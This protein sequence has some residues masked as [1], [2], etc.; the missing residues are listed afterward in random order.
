MTWG[1]HFIPLLRDVMIQISDHLP[2]APVL[3]DLAQILE[4]SG[5]WFNK[6][7]CVTA[8]EHG[9]G[10]FATSD[11]PDLRSIMRVPVDLMP[12]LSDFSVST[13]GDRFT[14]PKVI[15][16]PSSEQTDIMAMMID[17]YN[18]SGSLAAWREASPYFSLQEHAQ[19]FDYLVSGMSGSF[20]ETLWEHEGSLGGSFFT[21]RKFALMQDGSSALEHGAVTG[22]TSVLLPMVDLF[23][24][25]MRASGFN[26]SKSSSHENLRVFSRPDPDTRELFVR[27]NLMDAVG[28]YLNYGFVDASAP[29][30]LS[31]RLEMAFRDFKINVARSAAPAVKVPSAF[32]DIPLYMP[33]LAKEDNTVSLSKLVIPGPNAPNA[34]RRVIAL[35]LSGLEVPQAELRA[36]IMT[37]EAQVIEQNFAYWQK[38]LSLIV[39]IPDT[40]A[41]H[42]LTRKALAHLTAYQSTTMT[43]DV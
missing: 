42:H 19:V 21:S 24:H 30:M 31:M 20:P 28:S 9:A 33:M 16:S 36:Q 6:Q 26:F 7:S 12:R 37:F 18:Q 13:E 41:I 39:D 25:D 2:A 10:V 34:L 32:K 27:Y 29:F 43:K 40:H 15:G 1:L 8:T 17:I 23:N 22:K 14:S 4:Y 38:M 5:A 3:R 35:V 11:F